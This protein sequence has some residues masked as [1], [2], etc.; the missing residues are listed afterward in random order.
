MSVVM[1][2]GTHTCNGR[3]YT[4]ATLGNRAA[5][6]WPLQPI[7]EHPN[8]PDRAA[9]GAIDNQLAKDLSRAS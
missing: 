1:R 3:N 9:L 5:F 2:I 7:F 4:I 8:G 6:Q